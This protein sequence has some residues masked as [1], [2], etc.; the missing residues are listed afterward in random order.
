MANSTF[1]I[2]EIR[3][4]IKPELSELYV[5][6]SQPSDGMIGVQGWWKKTI[7]ASE[8]ALTTLQ[9]ALETQD[10]FNWDRGAP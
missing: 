1:E 4:V 5:L 10:F 9:Q 8:Q 6:L 7:P 2:L 3:A